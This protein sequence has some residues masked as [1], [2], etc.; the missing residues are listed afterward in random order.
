MPTFRVIVTP[1]NTPV[2]QDTLHERLYFLDGAGLAHAHVDAIARLMLA[3]VVTERYAID[4]APPA[5][6]A[7]VEI[8]YL[9]GVTD[10]VAESL[11]AAA[12]DS[13]YAQVERA[14]SGA[15]ICVAAD[16]DAQTLS[17]R[18]RSDYANEVIQRFVVN[19]EISA[20]FVSSADVGLGVVEE[21]AIAG[22]D[23]DALLALSKTRR[24]SL[25]LAEMQA[26]RDYYQANSARHRC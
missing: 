14:A 8:T 21:I 22:L 26:I 6:A 15:R 18:A 12:I 24:L 20:P 10:S 4:P 7:F 23:D 16:T 9:P 2:E 5:A 19:T 13:G 3:D 11:L 1:A 17:A 25:D